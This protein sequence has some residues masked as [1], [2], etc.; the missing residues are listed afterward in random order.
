GAGNEAKA[1]I[2]PTVT[3]VVGSN[4]NVKSTGSVTV[5]A[6]EPSPYAS[7]TTMGVTAGGIT[8]GV[9]KSLATISPTVQATVSSSA[10]VTGNSITVD[11]EQTGANA[12]TTAQA[13]GGG[14]AAAGAAADSE[15]TLAANVDAYV[16][17]NAV[18][19]T[20]TGGQD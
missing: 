11:A 4:A 18:L 2:D 14:V 13:S 16:G 15:A 5:L 8:V 3:A 20:P 1:T 9:S 12:T 17:K 10:I 6:S 7:A 19:T